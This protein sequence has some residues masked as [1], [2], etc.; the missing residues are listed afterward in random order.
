MLYGCNIILGCEIFKYPLYS[1][2]EGIMLQYLC[3]VSTLC[4]MYD[5]DLEQ[6]LR[7]L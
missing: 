2:L 6:H 5:M 3:N 4:H 1:G 7:D